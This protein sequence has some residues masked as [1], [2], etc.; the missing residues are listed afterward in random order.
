ME[1]EADRT[2]VWRVRPTIWRV[3]PS[4]WP[5]FRKRKAAEEAAAKKK[6]EEAAAKKKAE[7]GQTAK[8]KAEEE[9]EA[10]PYVHCRYELRSP[11][12]R[13]HTGNPSQLFQKGPGPVG[14]PEHFFGFGPFSLGANRTPAA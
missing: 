13:R 7:K 9:Q 14:A 11:Q 4:V 3:R 5:V 6:A 8:R 10:I 1:G 12:A 2:Y